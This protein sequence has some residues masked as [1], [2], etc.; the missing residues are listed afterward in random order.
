M[1]SLAS[2][3][4]PSALG[5]SRGGA[6][7]TDVRYEGDFYI[8]V[9]IPAYDRTLVQGFGIVAMVQDGFGPGTTNAYSFTFN[10]VNQDVQISL[11]T[12]D[13]P[14]NEPFLS[15]DGLTS[16]SGDQLRMVFMSEGGKMTGLLFNL[17]DLENPIGVSQATDTTY[18]SGVAGLVVSNFDPDRSG[19]TDATFDNYL[20]QRTNL[21]ELEINFLSES[22]YEV[23]FP[24]N[25]PFGNLILEES[26]TLEN[27][28]WELRIPSPRSDDAESD[29]ILLGDFEEERSFFRLRLSPFL[30]D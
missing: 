3:P 27:E 29:L 28:S 9:D 26:G 30:G 23:S 17:D 20:G 13:V 24:N 25:W 8:S 22:A 15:L 21:P 18:T 1:A 10:P 4:S 11:I 16:V 6:L 7:R 14:E 12:N 19:N 5:P 2:S